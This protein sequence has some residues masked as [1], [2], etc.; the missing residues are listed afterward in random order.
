VEAGQDAWD[1]SVFPGYLESNLH[2]CIDKPWSFQDAWG[3]TMKTNHICCNQ[4]GFSSTAAKRV[5]GVTNPILRPISRHLPQNPACNH[6]KH[7]LKSDPHPVEL[8]PPSAT[9]CARDNTQYICPNP[10]GTE[11]MRNRDIVTLL[12]LLMLLVWPSRP[13]KIINEGRTIAV[14]QLSRQE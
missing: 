12:L 1:K 4:P 5:P 9:R 11:T 8:V 10:V 6:Q 13:K 7:I 14:S 3:G 2:S